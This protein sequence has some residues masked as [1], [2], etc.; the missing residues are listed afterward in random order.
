MNG[1]YCYDDPNFI[2]DRKRLKELQSLPLYRKIGITVAR[3]LEWYNR[4]DGKVFISFSGGIDSTVLLDIARKCI[5]DI[6]AVF[7][8][9]GLEYPELR[10]FVKT[11][12]NVTWVKPAKRFDEVI[13]EYGYPVISKEVSKNLEYAQRG[14]EWARK[15]MKGLDTY[16]NANEW[17]SRYTKYEYLIDAPFKISAKCCDIMKK[18][19]AHLYARKTGKK[20]ILGTMASESQLRRTE[21]IKHGCNSYGGRHPHST[22]MAFWTKEDVLAYLYYY[23]IPYAS[24]YGDI[25]MDKHCKLYNTGVARTGCVFCM[26]GL[27]LEKEPNRFQ[28]LKQTHPKLWEYCLKS[29]DDGGLGEQAVCEYLHVPYE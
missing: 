12:D 5:P 26:Y 29:Q 28:Q 19:P 17:R 25:V 15:Y 2:H 11:I 4:W 20:A 18:A 8:D 10:E 16:G 13:K 24:V 6:E 22:P 1:N 21:W 23:K 9:T 27:H 3:I 14:A 7:V